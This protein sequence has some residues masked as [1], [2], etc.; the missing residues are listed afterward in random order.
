MNQQLH[1]ALMAA[2]RKL[3][4]PLVRILLR[5][6]VSCGI[7]IEQ[8]KRVYVEVGRSEFAVSGRKP[9]ISR[10]AV[11]TGLTRKEVSRLWK[12]PVDAAEPA[13]DQ[14][15]RA[16]RVISG[17]VRDDRYRDS[18]GRPASLPFHSAGSTLHSTSNST[19]DASFSEL[20]AQ[21]S[22]DMP[23]RAVLDELIRVGAVEELD[24]G[25]LNLIERAYV[26][27]KGEEEKLGILGADVA[28][29][30]TTIDHNL[31]CVPGDAFVQRKVSYDNLPVECLMTLR[32]SAAEAAQA[33]LENFDR[34]MSE[35]DRDST[36]VAEGTGRATASIGIY[37]YQDVS[38]EGPEES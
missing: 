22:G 37:F 9:S 6:E 7:F 4:R 30:L 14:Y 3:L 12:A 18:A 24:D 26:P 23:P 11:L 15:N 32:K 35:L 21:H 10:T 13:V 36:P 29:L 34:Q 38:D 19:S 31:T 8:V 16:A 17:W 28:E 33:V 5:S 25:S 2:A 27:A 1:N 20:V